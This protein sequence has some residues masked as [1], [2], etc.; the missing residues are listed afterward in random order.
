MKIRRRFQI[1]MALLLLGMS[2]WAALPALAATV[3]LRVASV[4]AQSGGSIDVPIEAVGAPGLGALHL[5][6]AYDPKVL[7]P[8][9][10]TRGPLA[11]SNALVDFNPA[12][13]GRLLIGVVSLDAIKGDGALATVRFK[14]IGDAGSSSALT[15]DSS[16]AWESSTRGSAGEDRSGQGDGRRRAAALA[17]RGRRRFLPCC[18]FSSFSSCSCAGAALLCNRPWRSRPLTPGP[19]APP[20]YNTG[21]ASRRRRP[22]NHFTARVSSP[23][24]APPTSRPEFTAATQP[25]TLPGQ[26]VAPAPLG[27]PERPVPSGS[28][29]NSDVFKQ[30]EDQYFALKGRLAAGRITHEQFEAALKDLMIRDPQGRYWMLGVDSGKWFVHNGQ[31]WVEGSR[32]E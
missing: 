2:G 4:E 11:G 23:P 13:A 24:A 9:T 26:S 15:L 30:A 29:P 25:P 32:I 22:D 6:L 17:V 21:T 5:E 19:A 27:L 20:A 16:K 3:T 28:P 12:N 7:T 18:S 14:V 10:V 31:T 1:G 8:D